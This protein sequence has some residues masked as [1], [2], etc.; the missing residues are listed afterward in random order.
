LMNHLQIA[1]DALAANRWSDA[2]WA[3]AFVFGCSSVGVSLHHSIR[4]L[5]RTNTFGLE[6]C[7]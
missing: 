2:W 3:S 4:R 1:A 5:P 6:V 7:D